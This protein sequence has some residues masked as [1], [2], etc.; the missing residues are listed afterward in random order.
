MGM[1]NEQRSFGID[2]N[3]SRRGLLLAASNALGDVALALG[4]RRPGQSEGEAL[5]AALGA[6]GRTFGAGVERAREMGAEE[7]FQQWAEARLA[8]GD[9]GSQEAE[10]LQAALSGNQAYVQ[11]LPSLMKARTADAKYADSLKPKPL[12]QAQQDKRAEI[13]ATRD[14]FKRRGLSLMDIGMMQTPGS[15]VSRLFEK[16]P[17]NDPEFEAMNAWA[18]AAHDLL[19]VDPSGN[20]ELSIEPIG[21]K[22]W[23]EGWDPIR[24]MYIPPDMRRRPGGVSDDELENAIANNY[25]L[26][27]GEP[28]E[29]G[30]IDRGVDALGG[31][32]DDV[33]G[34]GS[35]RASMPRGPGIS[36]EPN[37][38]A[39]MSFGS[40]A[41]LPPVPST[42][43]RLRRYSAAGLAKEAAKSIFQRPDYPDPT[44]FYNRV[45]QDVRDARRDATRQAMGVFGY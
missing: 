14:F 38:S 32:L 41:M 20:R 5:G 17:G 8:E 26:G 31:F 37:M 15:V 33:L 43:D 2:K 34:A 19:R 44:G 40:P 35:A 36:A 27:S 11:L 7:N 3:L 22:E 30:V 21:W 6:G 23:W 4:S 16:A 18:L 24:S 1:M 45:G 29:Q 12:T 9:I 39:P 13:F 42:F 25:G 10:I 28:P